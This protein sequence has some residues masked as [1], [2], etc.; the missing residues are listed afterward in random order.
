MQTLTINFPQLRPIQEPAISDP[1]SV[2]YYYLVST[3]KGVPQNIQVPNPLQR[4]EGG[5]RCKHLRAKF[6]EA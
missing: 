3:S 4:V 6:Q 2:V 1:T 5:Q